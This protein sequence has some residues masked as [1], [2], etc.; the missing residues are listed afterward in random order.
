MNMAVNEYYYVNSIS[1]R[2]QETVQID[3]ILPRVTHNQPLAPGDYEESGYLNDAEI[4]EIRAQQLIRRPR[5]KHK[6][7]RIC[8]YGLITIFCVF[9]FSL[10]A[11]YI[12][13]SIIKLQQKHE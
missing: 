2:G 3:Q 1:A 5:P 11:F 4:R 7:S 10:A 12:C 9:L 13:E 8:Y 6:K